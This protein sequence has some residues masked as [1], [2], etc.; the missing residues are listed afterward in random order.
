MDHTGFVGGVHR[1]A[2]AAEEAHSAHERG[3]L[4]AA[5]EPVEHVRE[6]SVLEEWHRVEGATVA[7]LARVVDGDDV[8][9]L[10][11]GRELGLGHEASGRVDIEAAGDPQHF[12]GHLTPKGP[13]PS[14]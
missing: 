11:L 9:V 7:E 14:S 5:S 2:G 8:R 13:I 6:G 3:L 4:R 1:H 12:H 10:E